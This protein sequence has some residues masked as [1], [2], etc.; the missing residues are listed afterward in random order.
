MQNESPRPVRPQKNGSMI[1]SDGMKYI[2]A[3][4][5]RARGSYRWF[6]YMKLKIKSEFRPKTATR[7]KYPLAQVDI[8]HV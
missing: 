3:T 5:Y 7:D 8:C 2:P 1:S 4:G 6:L